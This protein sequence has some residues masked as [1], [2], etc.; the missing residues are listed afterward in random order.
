MPASYQLTYSEQQEAKA[1]ELAARRLH[2]LL[3]VRAQDK[4]LSKSRARNYQ[5]LCAASCDQ[6]RQDLINVLEQQRRQELEQLQADYAQAVANLGRAQK[7]AAIAAEREEVQ[8]ESKRKLLVRRQEE[9]QMRFSQA[10]AR[11][12]T[13]KHAQL[14]TLMEQLERKKNVMQQERDLSRQ[15]AA[16]HKE[17]AVLKAQQEAYLNK[18]EEERR[19]RNLYSQVDF[20]YSRLHELGVSHLVKNHQKLDDQAPREAMTMAQQTHSR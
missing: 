20:K 13:A 10:I 6:L 18:Q 9:A 2:R 17:A 12:R 3:Q 11:I 14:Q 8:R 1:K 4:Q 16:Q 5:A 7:D 15:F 19:K